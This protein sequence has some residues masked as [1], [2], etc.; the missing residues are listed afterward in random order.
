MPRG[1]GI[2]FV[3][4]QRSTWV[5]TVAEVEVDRQTGAVS[6]K[7]MVVAVDPGIVV[8]PTAI[9]AQIE[10]ATIFATSRALKE[11]VKFDQSKLTTVDWNSYPI[12]RFTEIPDIEIALIDRPELLPGGIGEPPNTTR[13]RAIGNA[14]YD[15]VGVR[16]RTVPYVND[17]VKA[18]LQ[19]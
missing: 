18:A 10:G 14:I 7:R 2:S 9:K 17:A 12:L 5:A 4:S 11:E 15:A 16:L 6:A 19:A 3:A 1:R 13:R 8:N